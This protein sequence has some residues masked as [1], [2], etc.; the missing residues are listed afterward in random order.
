MELDP[1]LEDSIGKLR[2]VL[3]NIEERI[4]QY[5][6]LDPKSKATN[7]FVSQLTR[8]HLRKTLSFFLA[9]SKDQNPVPFQRLGTGTLNTLVFAL[10]SAIAELKKDNV[11]FAMEEP[12]IAVSPHTQRRIVNYLLNSTSQSFIT[13]HSPYIIEMF[14]PEQIK[15]LRKDD[16]AIV[17]ST[18]V[19]LESGLKAKLF[20]KRIRHSIAEAILGQAVIVGEGLCEHQVLLASAEIMEESNPDYCPLDLSGVT[21]FDADGDGNVKG[22]GAFFK[23]LGLRTFAYYDKMNRTS[24]QITELESNFEI[25][26][27]TDYMGIDTLLATEIPSEIQWEYLR[28]LSASGGLASEPALPTYRPSDDELRILTIKILKNKKG[29]GR[30]SELIRHCS[31]EQLP[32]SITSFLSKVYLLFPKPRPIAPVDFIDDESI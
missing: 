32:V 4:N 16:N 9:T 25:N 6:P 23:S 15:I 22:Y 8:D 28:E 20:K 30:A 12:E 3:D 29:E 10:L 2:P 27:Q 18:T 19:T 21:V 17:S 14:T 26:M 5:I 11:I 13:S 24:D 1:P 31:I 7:L